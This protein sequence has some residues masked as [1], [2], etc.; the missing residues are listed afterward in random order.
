MSS[1]VT[2]SCIIV[3]S[4]LFF[5]GLPAILKVVNT[6]PGI[7]PEVWRDGNLYKVKTLVIGSSIDI[8]F[9]CFSMCDRS[10]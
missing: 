7:E 4:V 2:V 10:E 6:T 3:P 8:V 9:S 5:L 1:F